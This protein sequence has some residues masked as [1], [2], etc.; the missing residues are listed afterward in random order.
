[1]QLLSKAAFAAVLLGSTVG[2]PAFAASPDTAG[3]PPGLHRA[4]F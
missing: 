1:M 2:A 3:C 4:E